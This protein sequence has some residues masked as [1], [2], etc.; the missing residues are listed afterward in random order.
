MDIQVRNET[1]RLT[2]ERCL[3][4]PA[5]RLLAVADL[6]LGRAE[7]FRR[8]GL[9]LP[10][11]AHED[12]LA[13]LEL[14]AAREGAEEI[15]FLGDFVHSLSGVTNDTTQMF[16]AW[17][18]RFKGRVTVLFGNHDRGLERHWPEAWHEIN[19]AVEL[20]QDGFLFRHEP[21]DEASD[22]FCWAGHVHPVVN[23]HGGADRLRLPC[24]V[25]EKNYGLLPAFTS[26]AGGFAVRPHRGVH[27]YA[28]APG[29]VTE[30]GQAEPR[31]S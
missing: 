10:P 18:E 2:A 31:V 19:R 4:W 26:L 11:S 27:V 9:W 17:R 28:V 5:R 25:V 13:R 15:I 8:N 6:H 23:L 21:P 14:C 20:G 16:A 7:V 29:F 1:F 24:F 22:S 12:D 30:V 3:F